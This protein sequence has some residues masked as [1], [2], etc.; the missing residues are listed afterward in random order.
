MAWPTL[1]TSN[2]MSSPKWQKQRLEDLGLLAEVI[3]QMY[4]F[5]ILTLNLIIDCRYKIYNTSQQ[6]RQN[7]A[8][9]STNFVSAMIVAFAWQLP[10]LYP[11]SIR[12]YFTQRLLSFLLYCLLTLTRKKKI[13]LY[14]LLHLALQKYENNK[15]QNQKRLSVDRWSPV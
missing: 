10:I 5:I 8:S 6:N 13:S 1:E 3:C 14:K 11:L 9:L 4:R 15:R 7:I 12:P 2:H